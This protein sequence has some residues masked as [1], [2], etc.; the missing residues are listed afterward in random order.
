MRVSLTRIY[1][2]SASHRLHS[3]KL[4]DAANVALFRECNNQGGH[5][6]NFYLWVTVTGP[7]DAKTGMI[8]DLP[9][10]DRIVEEHALKK[11]DHRFLTAEYLQLPDAADHPEP[12]I[13]TSENIIRLIYPWIAAA[14]PPGIELVGLR[15]D[16]TASNRFEYA[17]GQPMI[18]T[19]NPLE[20]GL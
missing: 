18:E 2:F 13:S 12:W 1:H 17:G 15:L 20:C 5:G 11:V 9:T 10:L 4:D 3:P 8:V 16:E 6:H 7:L 14:L 19:S